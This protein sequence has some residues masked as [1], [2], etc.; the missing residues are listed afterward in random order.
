MSCYLR[1]MTDVLS[2]AGIELTKENRQAVDQAIHC[3]VGVAYKD[4]PAA[5]REIKKHL[6]GGIANRRALVEELRKAKL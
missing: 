6:T 1:H 5:W 3:A 4:C 2:E